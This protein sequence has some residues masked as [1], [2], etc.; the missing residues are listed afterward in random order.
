MSVVIGSLAYSRDVD[1]LYNVII[2]A[3]KMESWSKI[4][5]LSMDVCN[6]GR[7]VHIDG[8]CRSGSGVR[9][10]VGVGL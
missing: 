10:S 6:H 4:V 5:N 2:E 1:A 8:E 3:Y 7:I 9:G